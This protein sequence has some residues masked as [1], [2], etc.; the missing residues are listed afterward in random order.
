MSESSHSIKPKW[1]ST[2]QS[3]IDAGNSKLESA[4]SSLEEKLVQAETNTNSGL[5]AKRNERARALVSEINAFFSTDGYRFIVSQIHNV[6]ET[7]LMKDLS[8]V[9]RILA[10]PEE[11]KNPQEFD[12]ALLKLEKS[13]DYMKY[14]ANEIDVRLRLQNIKNVGN[15]KN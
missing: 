14:A 11:E 8:H 9:N 5:V 1:A 7:D 13:F 4:L 2:V 15:Q 3:I 10:L 6:Q 12:E